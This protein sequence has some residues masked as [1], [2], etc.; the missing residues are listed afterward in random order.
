MIEKASIEI[1]YYTNIKTEILATVL[2]P[3]TVVYYW[4]HLVLVATIS[5]CVT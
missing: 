3:S 4:Y 2:V 5:N 1:I